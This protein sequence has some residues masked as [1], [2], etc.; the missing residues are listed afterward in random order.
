[1]LLIRFWLAEADNYCFSKFIFLSF[2]HL[3]FGCSKIQAETCFW[4]AYANIPKIL[5]NTATYQSPNNKLF[6][7]ICTCSWRQSNLSYQF[8]L[9]EPTWVINLFSVE[10]TQ[11]MYKH[12][13]YVYTISS[14]EYFFHY[15][16]NKKTRIFG[17]LYEWKPSSK[18][19]IKRLQ[20]IKWNLCSVGLI[21]N[22]FPLH[23]LHFWSRNTI[24]HNFLNFW[25]QVRAFFHWTFEKCFRVW[26][27]NGKIYPLKEPYPII[28][29]I[30]I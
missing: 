14:C 21:M 3:C 25:R 2:T 16:L 18:K 9:V 10:K 23:N 29:D 22:K 8:V 15:L 26:H 20:T 13:Q 27:L 30:I 1:M 4:Y 6:F 7:R 17:D 5:V 11:L 19:S 24:W 28:A 12:I